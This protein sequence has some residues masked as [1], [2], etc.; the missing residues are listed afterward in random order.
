MFVSFL[1]V[2]FVYDLKYYLILDKVAIPAMIAALLFNI[3]LY[4]DWRRLAMYLL[5]AVIAGGF[6]FFQ[7]AVSHGKWIGGGDIRLGFLMGL[8]LGWPWVITA[9]VLAY[10][11]GALFSLVLL[12]LK[13]KK[14]SSHIPFGTFLSV[15]TFLALFWADKLYVWYANYLYHLL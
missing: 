9:L 2:I 10:I 14:L 4:P 5:A 7:Y 3:L 6:F 8:M 13:K 11:I 15:G 1:L 12:A